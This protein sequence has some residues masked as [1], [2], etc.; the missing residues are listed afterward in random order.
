MSAPERPGEPSA[1][2]AA[3]AARALLARLRFLLLLGVIAGVAVFWRPVADRVGRAFQRDDAPTAA[4]FAC[5]MHPEVV[6]SGPDSCPACGMPLSRRE[7]REAGDLPDGVRARLTLTPARIAQAGLATEVVGWRPLQ[8]GIEGAGFLRYDEGRIRRIGAG[9]AGRVTS[10][11]RSF[12]GAFVRRGDP[13]LRLVGSDLQ[14]V[15]QSYANS[16]RQLRDAESRSATA[17]IDRLRNQTDLL[18]RQLLQWGFD[19]EQLDGIG[20]AADAGDDVP[21][22]APYDCVVLH[23]EVAAG[24]QFVVG[25]PLV[26][27]AD[28][29]A[30]VAVV[31][32]PRLDAR[33]VRPG[34]RAVV[35]DAADPA[36]T[37]AGVV[38]HV[39]PFAAEESQSVEV[40]VA[41]E[42]PVAGLEPGAAVSASLSI[43][44]A[45]IEPWR[46]LPRPA[47][48]PPRMVYECPGHQVVSDRPGICTQCGTMKLLPREIAG[49]PQPGEVL[50]VPAEAVIASGAGRLVYV[51][52]SPGIF[53]AREVVLGPRAGDAYAVVSGLD[54]GARVATRASFLLDAEARLDPAI[55]GTYFGAGAAEDTSRR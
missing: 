36:R 40:R 53:D 44:V 29:A 3:F 41:L 30:L 49:G 55:A 23:C 28:P 5:P 20:D 33:H 24:Q 38:V 18:R 16:A 7:Q 37:A 12:D 45:E 47:A 34:L 25:T 39:V 31:R 6:R 9:F 17:G 52:T 14:S 13:L 8:L 19:R 51:E 11:E 46:S 42:A 50:A 22:R 32:V 15:L 4:L 35:R 43:P 26:H 48:G 54:A 21:L 1:R 27:L 10:T 2:G